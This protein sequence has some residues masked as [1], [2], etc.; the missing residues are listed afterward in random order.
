MVEKG[1]RER[2]R[3][4]ELRKDG[5]SEDGKGAR[6]PVTKVGNRLH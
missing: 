6:P 4:R 3:E 1:E 2:E 5:G